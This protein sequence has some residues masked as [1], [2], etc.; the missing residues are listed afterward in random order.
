MHTVNVDPVVP[1]VERC[2]MCGAPI[3]EGR[4]CCPVCEANAKANYSVKTVEKIQV[5][6]TKDNQ[7]TALA[8]CMVM[9]T[10][11]LFAYVINS[12]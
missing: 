5:D 6:H 7:I 1:P 2:V 11:I 3:P 4:Q 9:L 12:I 10:A 8:A